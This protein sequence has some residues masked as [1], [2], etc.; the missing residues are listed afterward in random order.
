LKGVLPI[1]AFIIMLISTMT[2]I[3]Q[4]RVF[5]NTTPRYANVDTSG[6]IVAVRV[7]G[8]VTNLGNEPVSVNETDVLVFDYPLNTSDQR[9]VAVKAW[10]NSIEYNYTIT[11]DEAGNWVLVI[12]APEAN[13]TLKPGEAINAGVEYV[14]RV[15]VA[16]RIKPIIDFYRVQ[17]PYELLPVAGNWSELKPYA[18]E[19]TTGLTS[20]WNY[21]HPLIRLVAR[22]I[23]ETGADKPLAYL[24]NTLRWLEENVIYSTRVPPRYPWEVIVEG[25]GDCDDQSNL[26]ITLLRAAGIPSFLE[27]GYVYVGSEFRYSDTAADGLFNYYFIGGGAHGWVVVYIPPWEWI[28]VDPVVRYDPLTGLKQPLYAVAVKGAYYYITP[29]VVVNRVFKLDY[30]EES[31]KAVEEIK[32]LKLKY[33]VVLEVKLL[34]QSSTP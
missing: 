28:K 10:V 1:L 32:T 29:I 22:Y 6:V 13:T 24:L 14:V 11:S 9:V 21:T 3:S 19:T 25:A 27:S 17:S 20:L 5:E 15:D 7:Y 26:L 30:V 16:S 34:S 4:N 33:V 31:V 2:P 18:N 23:N 8:N 12:N